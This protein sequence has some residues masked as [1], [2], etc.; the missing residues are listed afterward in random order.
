MTKDEFKRTD[1]HADNIGVVGDHARIEGG[2]HFHGSFDRLVVWRKAHPCRFVAVLLVAL[3]FL[4]LTGTELAGVLSPNIRQALFLHG[5]WPRAFPKEREGEVL[6]VIANFQYSENLP[7]T[8]AHNEIKRAI[9]EAA[10]DLDFAGLRVAVDPNTCL[11]AADR[12]DAQALGDR[13]NASLIIWGADTGVRV[14][15]NFYNRKQPDFEAAAVRLEE[16][17]RTQIA[18]P[19]EYAAFITQDLPAQLTFLSLF[20]VGQSYYA[21]ETYPASAQAIEAAVARLGDSP[22]IEGAANAYFLLGWLYQVFLPDNALALVYY[23]RALELNPMYAEVYNCR[24]V[25]YADMGEYV[26]ALADFTYQL[27]LTPEDAEAYNNRGIIH[28]FMGNYDEALVD[29][30]RALE[31]DPEDAVTYNNRGIFYANIR[32][33]N[34]ALIDYSHALELEPENTM[35]YY[36]RGSIYSDIGEYSKA[37]ADFNHILDLNPEDIRVYSR[38]GLIYDVMGEY[39]KALADYNRAIELNPEDAQMVYYNRGTIFLVL[40]DHEQALADY[41]S[42]LE[43]DP[44]NE[45]AVLGYN[46][47]GTIYR[48]LGDY[49]KALADYTHALELDP[50]D[51]IA[52]YNIA[53]LHSQQ[54]RLAEACAWL[55]KV[56]VLDESWREA[57]RTDPAFDPIRNAPCFQALMND[58]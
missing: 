31:L 18:A 58:E 56:I 43:L 15:V 21:A 5:L 50:N 3:L 23:T 12:A 37:L 40:G 36:N 46:N 22:T 27:E 16:T 20:A 42:V 57:A 47:R 4:V 17:L 48:A 34:K 51:P 45:V 14:S 32:Q 33:Y 55:E 10:D 44:N 9:E 19:S 13:Y 11:T 7:N 30:N 29:Y 35:V 2:I 39:K 1:I 41:T 8:E 49:D 54:S 52:S 38:R 26:K 28:Y 53:C 24:G 6:I 25:I